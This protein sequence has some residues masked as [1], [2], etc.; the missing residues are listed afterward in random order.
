MKKILSVALVLTFVLGFVGCAKNEEDIPSSSEPPTSMVVSSEP[1]S[2][3]KPTS[4]EEPVSSKP[5][6]SESDVRADTD[7]EYARYKE[8]YPNEKDCIA[9]KLTP[10]IQKSESDNNGYT[11]YVVDFFDV[12]NVTLT[13]ELPEQLSIRLYNDNERLYASLKDAGGQ[14]FYSS[15]VGISDKDDNVIGGISSA[16]IMYPDDLELGVDCS[17]IIYQGCLFT[18][19][20]NAWDIGY[21]PVYQTDTEL[22]ATT[23]KSYPDYGLKDLPLDFARLGNSIGLGGGERYFFNKG[24]LSYN[25]DKLKYVAVEIDF[26]YISDEE[27]LCS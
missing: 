11:N 27:L 12:Y 17:A 7:K 24:I 10:V 6:L 21:N 13:I 23:Y 14:P 3:E 2:S 20:G 5:R 18:G 1:V 25:T 16:T 19:M 15:S 22:T 26:D 9:D 8:L 4:S